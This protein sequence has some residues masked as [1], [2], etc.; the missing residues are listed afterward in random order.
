MLATALLVGGCGSAE[1][2]TTANETNA[3]PALQPVQTIVYGERAD[4]QFGLL[5]LP[6]TSAPS[7]GHPVVVLVH[8]GFWSEPWDYTL[9]S[10][11]ADD[12]VA[13][14]YATWNIEFGRVG[15]TGGYP[16]TFDDVG[17][18]IDALAEVAETY[19]LDLQRAIIV[20]HSS[21]GH[22]ALWALDRPDARVDLVGAVG[23]AAVVDLPAFPQATGLLGGSVDEQPERYAHAAPALDPERVVLVHGEADRIV[24]VS[25][26][27]PAEV[28]GVTIVVIAEGDH[29]SVIDA[30]HP[31]WLA[32]VEQIDRLAGS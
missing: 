3:I 28:A 11:L 7:A 19:P 24:P 14:G 32:A 21:G 16:S 25:T 18:A 29:F 22:L 12:L 6:A 27:A 13:R 1:S 30:A 2:E 20:G 26:L 31:S 4:E 5:A 9:M 23:L 8:G 17:A 15:G 10:A